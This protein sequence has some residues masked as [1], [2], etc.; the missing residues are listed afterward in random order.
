MTLSLSIPRA[1]LARMYTKSFLIHAYCV[2]E[3]IHRIGAAYG[4]NHLPQ[5]ERFRELAEV[6]L[7]ELAAVDRQLLKNIATKHDEQIWK[8]HNK[9][10]L[11]VSMRVRIDYLPSLYHDY[12]TCL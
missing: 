4:V 8:L 10:V 5:E 6:A 2:A 1:D 3:C 12:F 11:S 7:P 9:E